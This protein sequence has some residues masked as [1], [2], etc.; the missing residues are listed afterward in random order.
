MNDTIRAAVLLAVLACPAAAAASHTV[1][2]GDHLWGLAGKY[3]GNNF[4]WK[5]I[6]AA[7][8]QKI[9]DPHWIYPGQVFEIPDLPGPEIG[10]LPA[11]PVETQASA[12]VAP[13]AD[14][15]K[16]AAAPA[17]APQPPVARPAKTDDLSIKM[18]DGLAGQYPSMTRRK[19]PK[20][21]REDGRVTEFEGRELLAAEGDWFQAKLDKPAASGERFEVLRRVSE[22]ELD[23]DSKGLYLQ[24][25]GVAQIK[26]ADGGKRYRFIILKSGDSIQV[27]D[28]LKREV[29]Q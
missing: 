4:R 9:K 29:V 14:E 1:V 2:P 22:Q 3:Y 19:A 17:P 25:V 28:L 11:R 6:Y 23:D 7:N 10:E 12:P 21:W 15:P 26:S 13:P 24:H 27:G 20:S 8:Q 18:P 5:A 16:V